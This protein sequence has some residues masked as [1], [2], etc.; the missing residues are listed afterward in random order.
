MRDI[1]ISLYKKE[2]AKIIHDEQDQKE[3][4]PLFKEKETIFNK[5]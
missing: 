4:E 3:N 1:V 2:K 5:L